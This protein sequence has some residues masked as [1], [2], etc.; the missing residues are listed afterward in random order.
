[1][2]IKEY[3]DLETLSISAANFI[4]EIAE[5]TINTQGFFTIALSGGNSPRLI[6]SM[7][8]E[9]E[10][11]S[12]ID[13]NKVLI[14]WGD[15][16]YLPHTNPES[17]YKMAYDTLIS[18]I[19]IPQENIFRIPTEVS[20]PE[21]AALLYENIM[22]KAFIKLGAIDINKKLPIFDLIILGVG[23][24]GH[25]ASLF[26]GHKAVNEKER[27][28]THVK[29]HARITL[30]DRITITLPV[31]NNAKNVMFIISGEGKGKIIRDIVE[32]KRSGKVY[33]ASM[34]KPQDGQSV[35]FIDK[36]IY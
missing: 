30:H 33:P 5:K 12:K 34:I 14:F 24:D 11:K 13:W 4:A 7:L 15:D 29:A 36:N 3:N 28:V 10:L 22:K 31:I 19:D 32:E 8:A 20:P 9:K 2:Q 21:E 18:K 26:P 17:N 1:M 6:Y 25:T 16:R 35:W 23:R 27:W